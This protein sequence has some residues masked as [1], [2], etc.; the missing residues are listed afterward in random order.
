MNARRPAIARIWGG[1]TARARADE[2]DAY[3]YDAGIRPLID[4]ALGVQ[5]FREDGDDY[6]EFVTVSYWESVE[7]MARV[8]GGDPM[9]RAPICRRPSRKARRPAARRVWCRQKDRG[10]AHVHRATGDIIP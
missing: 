9:R 5:P 3:N 6:T 1:R 4:N 8:T 10:P 7:A 2:Y